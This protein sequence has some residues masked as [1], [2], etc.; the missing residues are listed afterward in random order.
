ML[1]K[2]KLY[3]N[4][5]EITTERGLVQGSILSPMLFNLFIND[6]LIALRIQG[7]YTLAYAD[8]IA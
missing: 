7:I 8:D 2:F 6:L 1:E 3:Y 5:E 4:S